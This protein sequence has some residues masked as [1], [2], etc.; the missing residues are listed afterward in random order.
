MTTDNEPM[1]ARERAAMRLTDELDVRAPDA[2]H[3]HVSELVGS[4]SKRSSR[5]RALAGG[6]AFACVAAAALAIVF[7]GGGAS[8]PSVDDVVAAATGGPTMAAPANDPAAPGK[9]ALGV[10]G[11]QFPS[12]DDARGWRATGARSESV[13]GRP[14]DTVFYA[15]GAGGSIK[16]S[17]VSGAPIDQLAHPSD[18]ELTG[19]GGAKRLV[20]RNGGRTCI[21]ESRGVGAD[22]LERLIA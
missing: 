22:E 13:G 20:W 10:G 4:R 9:L 5:R 11:V 2:L 7:A 8:G 19:S 1:T 16:Y 15:D 12:W 14:V 21:I 17:I 6:V 18:Y 3:A